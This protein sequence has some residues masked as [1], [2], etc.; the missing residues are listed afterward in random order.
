ML[1]L[2]GEFECKLDGKN[3]LVFPAGLKKQLP[4]TSA[5]K[6]V[7]NRGFEQ[8]LG[9]YTV[10][11][12]ETIIKEIKKLSRYKK[13]ARNFLRYFYRGAT[14]IE[15]DGTNRLLLPKSLL[16]YA[17]IEKE[18]LV[19]A[20]LDRIEIWDKNKYETL[21][22]DEPEGYADLAEKVLGNIELLTDEDIS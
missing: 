21:I 14:E 2:K 8:C 15:L 5:K 19:F 1:E 17:G 10:E 22:T 4:L 12:W 6:F 16:K 7:I 11:A 18:V 20:Y 3:R 13:D 9:L